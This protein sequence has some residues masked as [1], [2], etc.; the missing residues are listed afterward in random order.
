MGD[1]DD[2]LIALDIQADKDKIAELEANGGPPPK[3][4]KK[5]Q[6]QSSQRQVLM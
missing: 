6:K 1:T 3:G 4:K 5:K 2:E